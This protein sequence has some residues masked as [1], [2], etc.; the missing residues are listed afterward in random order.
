MVV[1]TRLVF[2]RSHFPAPW[3]MEVER[4]EGS[5]SQ[6]AEHRCGGER[7][8][9]QVG[10]SVPSPEGLCK[11]HSANYSIFKH[12]TWGFIYFHE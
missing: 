7:A 3:I 5:R 6:D 10:R 4:R 1:L 11:R 8:D 12:L 2:A 9:V